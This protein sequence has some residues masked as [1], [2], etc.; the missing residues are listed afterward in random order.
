[1]LG[2]LRGEGHA[3]WAATVRLKLALSPESFVAADGTGRA[4]AEWPGWGVAEVFLPPQRIQ[5]ELSSKK[6][7]TAP[8]RSV[9]GTS[10]ILR[11]R[12]A[13]TAMHICAVLRRFENGAS[14]DHRP[15]LP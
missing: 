1:V 3:Y 10:A 11:G 2:T 8:D 14:K 4:V 12:D 7:R 13:H 5:L 15:I 9:L 6:L